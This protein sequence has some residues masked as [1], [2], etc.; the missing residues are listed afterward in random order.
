MERIGLEPGSEIGGYTIVAPLGSGGMG[1]VYRAVDGGGDAVALKLLHPHVGSDAATRDRL[2]REVHALQK[3]RHPGVAA[4]LDAEADSTEAFLVTELVSGDNLEE[5]VRERGTLDAEEL[6]GLAEGLRDTLVAVHGAGVVHRDLKP[7]NV[8]IGDDGP[9]LIDF[10]LAQ[11]ADDSKLT[12]DGLVLGTPGYLAPELLEGA[13]P[14]DASDFWGWAAILAFAATGRPPFGT[15]PLEAVLAR[16]RSG[17]V[18]LDGVGSLTATTLRGALAPAAADRTSPDDVVAALTLVVAEGEP[19]ADETGTTVL[20]ADDRAATAVQGPEPASVAV[21]PVAAP[22][23]AVAPVVAVN[24][25]HTRAFDPNAVGD[26]DEDWDEDPESVDW[27]EEDLD[28]SEKPEPEGSGYERPPA[29]RRWGTLLAAALLLGSAGALYPGVALVVFVLL[30]VVVR[31]V[32]SAVE[33]MYGRRERAGVRRSDGA[34]ALATAPWH[35][36]RSVVGLVPSLVVAGSVVI[37]LLGVSWWLIGN[38]HWVVGGSPSGQEPQGLTATILVGGLVLFGAA[39]VWWG[40]LSLMT[41]TGA[42]R[43][44]AVVAPGRLGALVATVVLLAA[45]AVFLAQILTGEPITWAPLPTPV[46]P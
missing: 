28:A 17:D 32:G 30:V 21:A 24:D 41:R 19:I 33:A 43:V 40:P 5:H 13:E 22:V 18:D 11:A 34:V 20:T 46:L 1:T 10:G 31:T 6:L 45:S 44:L 16:A 42:R 7:S 27:I 3:L 12:A 4:V 37:I 38:D 35:L 15:R 9:V 2:R 23:A 29:L 8:I 36:L 25:G 39:V 26:G 14:D